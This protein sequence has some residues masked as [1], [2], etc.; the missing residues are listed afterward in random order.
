MDK[1]NLINKLADIKAIANNG[2]THIKINGMVVKSREL[3]NLTHDDELK[4][5]A[6][7]VDGILFELEA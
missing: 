2:L 7:I 6:D 5:I 3:G 4:E 1:Q